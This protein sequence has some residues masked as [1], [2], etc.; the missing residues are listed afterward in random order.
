VALVNISMQ[1]VWEGLQA[2]S[3]NEGQLARLQATLER[4]DLIAS[5]NLGW[6]FERCSSAL[7]WTRVAESGPIGFNFGLSDASQTQSRLARWS[8]GLLIPK[9]WIYQN[10]LTMDRDY[11]E[12]FGQVLDP[13]HHVVHASIHR[14]LAARSTARRRTP[15]SWLGSLAMP[16]LASQNAR[17]ARSQS[18]L[19]LAR[20]ACAL[21]RHRLA[22][23]A[24]PEDL[25]SLVPAFLSKVPHDVVDAVPLRYRRE[26]NAFRLYSLGWNGSDEGGQISAGNTAANLEQGDWVW[27]SGK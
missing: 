8:W 6:Q 12:Q 10:L 7:R 22:R 16:S 2:R 11:Q 18:G 13:Q 4:L 15:Y 20:I 17:V 27:S 25:Q 19:D 3:W 23:G 24:Y 14:G 21:E 9:G 1:P 26:G 5:M